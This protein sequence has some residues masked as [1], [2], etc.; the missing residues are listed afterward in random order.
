LQITSPP[1]IASLY[2]PYCSLAILAILFASTGQRTLK[3]RIYAIIAMSRTTKMSKNPKYEPH[4]KNAPHKQ[5][6]KFQC[7]LLKKLQL[8][9]RWLPLETSKDG[10]LRRN[11]WQNL[12]KSFCN[13]IT[14][15][16]VNP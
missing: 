8:L 16:Q 10:Y 14:V 6:D 7:M 13:V 5:Y 1:R 11:K 2:S 3:L 12:D 4:E 9:V 15:P